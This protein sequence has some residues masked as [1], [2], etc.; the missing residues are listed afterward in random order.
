MVYGRIFALTLFMFPGVIPRVNNV[1]EKMVALGNLHQ[2]EINED[3]AT[4]QLAS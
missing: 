2:F 4:G 1:M 3:D